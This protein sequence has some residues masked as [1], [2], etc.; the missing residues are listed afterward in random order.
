MVAVEKY[1]GTGNDF[2]VVDAGE[3]VPD[4]RAFA[5][6]V[7]DREHGIGAHRERGESPDDPGEARGAD[8]VLYLDLHPDETPPRVT[9]TLVQPDGSTAAMCGNGARCAARWA[10]RRLPGDVERVVVDTPA[11]PRPATIGDV[12]TVEM[13][14]PAF[15]PAAVP[16]ESDGPLVERAVGGLT[17]TAVDTGVPHAVA[18]VDDVAAVDLDAVAPAVRHADVFPEGANVTLF[19]RREDGGFDQRTYER[20]VEGET[21]ACGTGAVAVVAV[22]RRLGLV[23]DDPVAVHPLGGRL[24]V[25]VTDEG[26][27]LAGPAVRVFGTELDAEARP[28]DD[29]MGGP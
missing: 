17:L 25:T 8:G 23:G 19:S 22:A 20:G 6:R 13:G 18:L 2:V 3:P 29:T 21:D 11:G 1:H 28:A 27:T 9:M 10:A 7:C 26:A 5:R 16:V 15:D 24:V 4:R 12:V 14:T